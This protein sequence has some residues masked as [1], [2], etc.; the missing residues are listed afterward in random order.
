MDNFIP[1]TNKTHPIEKKWMVKMVINI[2]IFIGI[3]Y[4]VC[5]IKY[6][7]DSIFII[8][9][10]IIY[11]WL[12]VRNYHYEFGETHITLKKGVISKSEQHVPYGRIQNIYFSQSFVD[13]LL[14]LA[15]L[16]IETASVYVNPR[17]KKYGNV[18]ISIPGLR[19]EN[20]LDL[21]NT[22]IELMKK[23]PIDDAQSGL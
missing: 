14:G 21:K 10:S 19:Y 7:K 8:T 15:S 22:V 3:V 1:K 13:K 4:Y 5:D 17:D 2:L 9:F 20:A 23:N 18:K 11:L 16:S 6:L 12:Y